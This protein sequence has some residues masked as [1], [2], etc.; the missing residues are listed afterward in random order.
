ML[1]LKLIQGAE[2]VPSVADVALNA[3]SGLLLVGT[4]SGGM[5]EK[6]TDCFQGAFGCAPAEIRFQESMP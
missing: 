4:K 3:H 6:F 1:R 2:P 5:L